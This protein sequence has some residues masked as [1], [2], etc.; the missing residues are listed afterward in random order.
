M[1]LIDF[2]EWQDSTLM[3]AL[4]VFDKI[5]EYGKIQRL[6]ISISC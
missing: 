6:S 5:G 4:K 1:Y 2:A 3:Y